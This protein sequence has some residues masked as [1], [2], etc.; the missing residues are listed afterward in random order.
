MPLQIRSIKTRGAAP[1]PCKNTLP[2]TKTER[3]L[4]FLS[5]TGEPALDISTAPPAR[6]GSTTPPCCAE[7]QGTR[8][9]I[10]K[11]AAK[12]QREAGKAMCPPGVVQP[13]NKARPD[14]G[15]PKKRGP[16]LSFFTGVADFR[17]D[18]LPQHLAAVIKHFNQA[19]AGS[20]GVGHRGSQLSAG[21][22]ADDLPLVLSGLYP[23]LV[24]L[25]LGHALLLVSHI[26]C[27]CSAGSAGRHQQRKRAGLASRPSQVDQFAVTCWYALARFL[28]RCPCPASRASPPGSV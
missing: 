15:S 6:E 28:R 16:L 3:G 11:A 7:T 17:D 19:G 1:P 8:V 22:Q 4:E 13:K 24:L 14:Y 9:A 20:A 23:K 2:E 25:P 26:A 18:L 12:Q 5:M 21:K 27:V 10:T